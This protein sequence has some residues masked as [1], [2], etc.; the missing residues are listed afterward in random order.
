MSKHH[1]AQKSGLLTLAAV[2]LVGPAIP[3]S[4]QNRPVP[5][6]GPEN[7]FTVPPDVPTAVVLQTEPDAA[8]DL[9]AAGVND[10]SHTMRL[11]AN[12]EGYIRFHFTPDQDIQDAHLQ[13]DCTAAQG[14]TTRPVH[15]RIAA[16]PTE[17][18]PAPE[19]SVPVP[20]GSKTL[21]ALTEEAS[22]QLR[23]EEVIE[24]GYPPRPDATT[25]P[26][27]Y[28]SWLD[29]V[30]RPMTIM[31]AH[32]VSRSDI[33]HSPRGVTEGA[34]VSYNWSGFIANAASSKTYALVEGQWRVPSVTADP[35]SAPCY[36]SVWVGLDGSTTLDL[37]QAGTEQDATYIFPFGTSTNY[38][39]WEEVLPNQPTAQELYGVN[40]SDLMKV[41][42]F[43]SNSKASANPYGNT[44]YFY[45]IDTNSG[46]GSGVLYYVPLG[47]SFKFAGN[48]AEWITE[49]PTVGG[50]LPELADYGGFGMIN[51]YATNVKAGT[52]LPYSTIQNQQDTMREHYTPV[53]SDNNVLSTVSS[54]TGH[55]DW[56]NFFWKNFH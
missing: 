10:S 1:I 42:V 54:A 41:T 52:T 44:A 28:A 32:A 36:S 11:Y 16:S 4:A 8:C 38:Y 17:D 53:T 5:K 43:V 46:S 39:A 30:S 13:L 23:D 45:V 7:H 14:L 19:A 51:A 26:D 29:M 2:L 33:T 20:K 21:P 55:A 22:G 24:R 15:L 31:P 40:S 25:S 18:M 56:M 34:S 49:R 6:L 27:A 35:S 48:S 47:S 37:V 3:A 9:H 50:S 12:M